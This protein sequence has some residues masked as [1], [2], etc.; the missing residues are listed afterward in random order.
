MNFKKYMEMT[1]SAGQLFFTMPDFSKATHIGDT[2]NHKIL[3]YEHQGTNVYGIAVDDKP[4]GYLQTMSKIISNE[5]VEEIL[6]IYV[7]S[8]FR[9][10]NLMKKLIFFLK[11]WLNKSFLMGRVQSQDGQKLI[12]S[13]AKTQRF[14]IFWL[15]IKT[16]EKH[17]Y[18]FGK[19]HANA[20]PYRSFEKPTD[21]QILIE[22]LKN[23]ESLIDSI[24][25]FME[26]NDWRRGWKWFD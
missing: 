13:L 3:H 18:E 20:Q 25:V 22:G 10:Q 21:W 7:E 4:M 11:S 5:P 19:D 9:G 6:K 14:P 15:N 26:E 17:P 1:M 24:P 8:Q 2:E 16:G 23:N 12:Q